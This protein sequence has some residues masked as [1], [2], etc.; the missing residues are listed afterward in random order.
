MQ[1]IIGKYYQ[2]LTKR[3]QRRWRR[4]IENHYQIAK[5]GRTL[6]AKAVRV[7]EDKRSFQKIRLVRIQLH[8]KLSSGTSVV[9]MTR[10]L[11]QNHFSLEGKTIRFKFLSGDLSQ[12]VLCY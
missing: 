10:C 7:Y 8:I 2:W 3:K 12:I 4:L 1:A 11:L 5:S 9:V 6:W